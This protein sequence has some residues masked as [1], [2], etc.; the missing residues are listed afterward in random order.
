MCRF[1]LWSLARSVGLAECPLC[2]TIV[3]L[4]RRALKG[5]VRETV[6][7]SQR[8]MYRMKPGTYSSLYHKTR[9]P[10]RPDHHHPIAVDDDNSGVIRYTKKQGTSMTL[11][12]CRPINFTNAKYIAS[13]RRLPSLVFV[14]SS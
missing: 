7:V 6:M 8:V 2:D 1:V 4:C 5:R 11:C 14:T 9:P 13:C 3:L 12:H 10:T